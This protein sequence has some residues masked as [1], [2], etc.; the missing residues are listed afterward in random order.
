MA[1]TI[2]RD[3]LES[4]LK[5]RYK[6]YLKLAGERGVP[7]DYE[8]LMKETRERVRQGARGL[9]LARHKGDKV[10]QGLTVTPALLS[11]GASLILDATVE[12]QGLSV[13]FDAI[14]R[15]DGRSSLGSFHYTPVLFHEAERPGR[16]QRTLL[17]TLGLILGSVQG[18][19]P[20]RGILIHGQD[21]EIRRIKLGVRSQQA[22]WTLQEIG[23]AQATGTSPRLML[24]PHCQICEFRERCHAKATAKEDLSLLR[25]LGEKEIVKYA[26]RGIVSVTQLS[27]T[28]R[29]RKK[30]KTSNQKGQPH[31]HALQALAVREK[32][33]YVLGTP[34]LPIASTR[35]YFDIEGD[36]ERRFDYLLGMTVEASGVVERHS[37]WADSPAEEPGL[38][39]QFLDVIGRYADFG[40]YCYGSYEVA[41][42]RRMI[43]ELKHHELIDRLLP[44]LINVLAVIHSHVYF[45][46]YSNGLKEIGKFLGFR[47]TEPDASGIQSIVWRRRWEET[48]SVAFKDKLTTYNL[49]DCAAL[50]RVTE[51]L[52]AICP[53]Q[54]LPAPPQSGVHEG[55]Q[56]SRV[57]EIGPQSSRREWCRAEFAIP[58]FAFV[59]KRAY[60][61]YQRDRVFIRTSKALK[62]RLDRRRSRKGKKT[63]RANHSVAIT[64]KE[65]PFCG[66]P[67]LS[68]T[69]DGRLARLAFDLR[70]TR[71]GIR[72][73]VTRFTTARHRCVRCG[74]RFL[75]KEYIGLDEH[76][77]SLKSWAM[78]EHVVHRAS[79]GKIAAKI[80][81]YFGLPVFA[82]DVHGFKLLLSRYY[83]ETYKRLLDKIVSGAFLHADESE[84]HVR[85]VGK[86]Y[87]WVFTNLEEVVYLY[88]PSREGDFLHDLL[89]DFRGVL[90]SDF[91][92][93]YDSLNC[94]QQ[95]CL[96]HLIRDLNQDIVGNPWDM[97][98]KSLASAFGSLLSTII[99]TIDQYG[100]KQ[101]HLGKHRRDV[102]R[103]FQTAAA[104][105]LHSEV[106]EGYRK[107]LLKYRDK[108]FTFLDHDGVPWN[109]NNA[110]HAVKGF[111]YYREVAD[112]L[113]TEPG[114][115][116]YLVLLSIYQT[117][118][119]KGVSFLK[120][121][122]SGQTDIDAFCENGG[123]KVLPAIE[124]YPESSTST[125]PSRKRLPVQ[126]MEG[127]AVTATTPSESPSQLETPC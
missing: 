80:T 61:D 63:L 6:G 120:F 122:L 124:L 23:K 64:S 29:P 69:Q 97:D 38:F 47:W 2:T 119:Y 78:Y 98:L 48:C 112:N 111:A 67:D 9:L 92:T 110:E 35:V 55:H 75:P 88:R 84:V 109:N 25:G 96:I 100:L 74:H 59:N 8:L 54:L 40:L 52:Y 27:C 62:K 83:E 115:K 127:G 116:Q 57:E 95:K 94:P 42:L 7:A 101:R 60:F 3:V 68:R 85:R 66:S 43:K 93:A 77:H 91:Y 113:F 34:E 44:R 50:K 45:P 118:K 49:E 123:K 1:I 106:A 15:I 22:R 104:V 102:D 13:C 72:R 99:A 4:Y 46:T 65:C 18:K 76:F 36:P 11:Q 56:V 79:F 89:K 30:H 82:P 71:S 105:P 20:G 17:E 81:D 73:W 41:F 87:V 108:L 28:F 33:V 31:Q 39:Q 70:I 90:V 21:C 14:R 107:R 58:D 37:F 5:C 24:N 12:G 86:G 19:E 51:F 16:E 53:G 32:K 117:C 121:L 26:R 103:F 126:A 125:R 10:L 114:L